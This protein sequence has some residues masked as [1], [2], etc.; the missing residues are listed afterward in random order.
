MALINNQFQVYIVL[1]EN[2]IYSSCGSTPK[3]AHA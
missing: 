2:D 3:R 1:Q